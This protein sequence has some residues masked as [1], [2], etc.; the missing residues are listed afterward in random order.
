M[1]VCNPARSG[2]INPALHKAYMLKQSLDALKPGK[3]PVQ[4]MTTWQYW[5][6]S[7]SAIDSLAGTWKE[8][9]PY[10]RALEIGERIRSTLSLAFNKTTRKVADLTTE[11]TRAITRMMEVEDAEGRLA[12]EN[13]DGSAT[14]T[15]QEDHVGVKKGET[16]VLPKA[17]NA[18]R[19][20]MRE[21]IDTL[22][23]RM[24]DATKAAMGYAPNEAITN[25]DDKARLAA[26]ESFRKAGYIPHIRTGRWGVQYTLNGKKHFESYGFDIRKGFKGSGRNVAEERRKTLQQMGAT[27]I[28][29]VLDM[30]ARTQLLEEYLPT[31]N[32]LSKMDILFQ[33]ILSP[34][35]KNAAEEVKKI[36][37][38]LRE[39]AQAPN[40]RLRKRDDIG[41]WLREDNYDTYLRSIFAPFVASTSDWVANKATENLRQRAIS[42]IRDDK[43]RDIAKNQEDYIH[44]DESK[45]AQMKSTAFL[46]TLGFNLSSALVNFT[47]MMHTSLPLLGGAG[48]AGRAAAALAKAVRDVAGG[49]KATL[50]P[51]SVFDIDKMRLT[52][53]EKEFLR[54]MYRQGVAEALLTRDQAP[55]YMGKSQIKEVYAAGQVL[56]RIMELSSLGF[57][58]VEQVN[59]LSTGL[60]AYR[61]AKDAK[62]LQSL[63]KMARNV[64]Q[65]V[66]TA[67]DAGIFAV[68]ETQFVTS[69]PFR[70][71]VMQGML[72]GVG[73][74]FMSFPIKMLG[75]WARSFKYYG[76]GKILETP[77]GRK[78]TGLLVMGILSTS[79]IWG[80]PFVSPA[81]DALDWL[82]KMLGKELGLTPTA[83]KTYMRDILK[84]VYK[85]VPILNSLGS[86]AELADM[87]LN[88]PF[89]ATGIDISKRTALDIIDGNPFSLDIFN[90]GPLG[91]AVAGG[92]RDFFNY[93][94]KGEDLMALASLM[95]IAARNVARAYTMSESGYITPGKIEPALPAKEMQEAGDFFKVAVGFT[96]T[97]VAR[98]RE[99]LQETKQLQE[100][101]DDLR[102]SYSDSIATAMAKY[103][104]T[105]DPTYMR[106]AQRLRQ[107]VIERDKNKPVQDRIIRDPGTFNSSISEKVKGM[108]YPERLDRVS[109]AFRPY[110]QER[111]R[112]K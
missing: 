99:A 54:E 94:S 58:M 53:D 81:G 37:D 35:N 86:P 101:T 90:F 76:G 110:Y 91:G 26:M 52:Q 32:N 30:Q 75:F 112:E 33:S 70:A 9:V 72:G 55:A 20:E 93:R 25:P 102:K 98:A 48:G 67:T 68:K 46:Y 96:P 111:L 39:E 47:Q 19:Q 45:I 59:R 66:V 89:R 15:A 36:L 50:D 27:E 7:F 44:S 31:L 57:T 100:R 83:T 80:L 38:S 16:V 43:L 41:G 3:D 11:Q 34:R 29:P 106:E 71:R 108:L 65:D 92:L 78:M 69:K 5:G 62:T 1:A 85:E 51:D 22:Y 103:Y 74:Q 13:A 73:L 40:P 88:G 42:A 79:G 61:M 87:T 49:G 17:L 6:S 95:P 14:I 109:P 23:S 63:Q 104:N 21:V 2:V 4:Q 10:V 64:N 84:D 18:T 56:G 12:K 28:S 82:T 77:E 107:E 60:A 24:V 97:K 8:L 105:K